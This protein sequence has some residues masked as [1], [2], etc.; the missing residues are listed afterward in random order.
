MATPNTPI[1]N[2]GEKYINGLQLART[3]D[4]VISIAA[5]AARDSTNINDIVVSAALAVSNL[6]S[7]AGGI[8]TGTVAAGKHYAVFVIADSTGYKA[9]AGL[10]SEALE[11]LLP[12][13]YDMWRRI[14]FVLT[15]GTSDW[16][17]FNQVGDGV[18]RWMFH[19]APILTDVTA[20]ASATY[21]PVDCANGLPPIAKRTEVRVHYSFIPTA[22]NDQLYL[23]P[24]GSTA[25][26]G[27]A[28]ASGSVAAVAK[29]GMLDC[30][31]STN[32]STALSY[33]VTGTAVALS[34]GGYMDPLG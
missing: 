20:G 28:V 4:E 24:G 2:A 29:T 26:I 19:D 5:G 23:V 27:Y 8:D 33:L 12:I 21:A 3:N 17:E 9:P 32:S 31:V 13:G 34:I 30:P 22:P 7:G 25:S 10:L 18:D 11:P 15:D 16:L 6:V 1:V 14:G